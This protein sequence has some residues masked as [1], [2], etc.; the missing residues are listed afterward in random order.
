MYQGMREAMIDDRIAVLWQQNE[1]T[2]VF[3]A[4]AVNRKV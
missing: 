4:A 2:D 1:L 3:A